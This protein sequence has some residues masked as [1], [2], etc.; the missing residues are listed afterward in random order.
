MTQRHLCLFTLLA[1]TLTLPGCSH[2]NSGA[3]TA[4]SEKPGL[5]E[6]LSAATDAY[7]YG[8]PLVTM[9]MTRLRLTS[10][11]ETGSGRRSH[12]TVLETADLPSGR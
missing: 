10:F 7:I 8:Y 12:G 3:E 1:L 9:D 11:A 5:T 4:A 6:A 2:T